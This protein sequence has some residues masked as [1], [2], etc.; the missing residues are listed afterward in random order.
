MIAMLGR[1][2]RSGSGQ[3]LVEFALIIPLFM[4]IAIGIFEGGR[5]IY[6]YNALSNAVNEALREAIVHQDDAA[7][8]AE[9]D[10]VLGGLANDTT[11]IH[12]KTDCTPVTSL[13]AYRVELRYTFRPVLI[14]NIFSPVIAADGEM[15]VETKNP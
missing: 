1:V 3:A 8:E 4:L 9:A 15:P 11:F 7:I 6:T 14:G 12:D 5:A 2:R 10:R 13:C